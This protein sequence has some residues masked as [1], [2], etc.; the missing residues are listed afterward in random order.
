MV[1]YSRQQNY[2]NTCIILAIFLLFDRQFLSFHALY[3]QYKANRSWLDKYLFHKI[4]LDMNFL[5]RL[6]SSVRMILLST[7]EQQI[8]EIYA[9]RRIIKIIARMRTGNLGGKKINANNTRTHV[10]YGNC[11]NEDLSPSHIF[12]CREMLQ[13]T[14]KLFEHLQ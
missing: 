7:V 3:K 13:S 2:S 4:A 8:C 5:T 6:I 11:C 12:S 1:L 10:K 9:N 14:A